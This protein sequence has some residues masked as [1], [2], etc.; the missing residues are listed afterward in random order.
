MECSGIVG[1]SGVQ[2]SKIEYCGV[3]LSKWGI[4]KYS[5]GVICLFVYILQH[6]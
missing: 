2:W 6:L 4:V 5:R 1:Y 3:Q